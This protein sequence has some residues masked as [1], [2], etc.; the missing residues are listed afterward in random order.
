MRDPLLNALIYVVEIS[1][2]VEVPVEDELVDLAPDRLRVEVDF[3][4]VRL[5]DAASG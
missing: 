4:D 1:E 3:P 2:D 5:R